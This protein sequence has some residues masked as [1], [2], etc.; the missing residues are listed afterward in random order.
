MS[1][2][3]SIP[4]H[5]S[6]LLYPFRQVRLTLTQ[7]LSGS[8]VGPGWYQQPETTSGVL[9]GEGDGIKEEDR[10]ITAEQALEKIIGQLDDVIGEAEKNATPEAETTEKIEIL[11]GFPS[12]VE[13][14][15]A[16]VATP[17]LDADFL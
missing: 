7:A 9:M 16:P 1:W 8:I 4:R 12:K 5:Y 2:E 6:G 17:L 15:M 3:D 14:G 10:M 13:G 11:A